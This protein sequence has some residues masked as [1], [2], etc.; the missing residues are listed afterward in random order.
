MNLLAASVFPFPFFGWVLASFMLWSCP[1]YIIVVRYGIDLAWLILG[2]DG[3]KELQLSDFRP[4]V[5]QLLVFLRR[6]WG[7]GPS[8]L[9]QLAAVGA[10]I[11]ALWVEVIIGR[12]DFWHPNVW[13]SGITFVFILGLLQIGRGREEEILTS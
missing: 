1:S 9:S 12:G 10:P 8:R 3:L 2:A 4:W 13:I 5:Q 6:V 7:P 11:L